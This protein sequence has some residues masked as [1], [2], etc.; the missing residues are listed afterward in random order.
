LGMRGAIEPRIF[1][2]R[3]CPALPGFAILNPFLIFLIQEC[4]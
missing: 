3:G 2:A 1:S 4:L